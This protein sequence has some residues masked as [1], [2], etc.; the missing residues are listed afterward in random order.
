MEPSARYPNYLCHTCAAEA[1][2]A[3]GRK[4]EFSNE[5]FSGGYVARY[6]DDKTPYDS[7]ECFVR[8]V[9][10]HADEAHMGGIVIRPR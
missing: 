6:A 10:C 3:S 8:G 9:R 7:H 1:A 2:D 4:L 5:S